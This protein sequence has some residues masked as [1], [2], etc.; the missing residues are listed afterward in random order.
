MSDHK[1]QS[2]N[3]RI[4]LAGA[5]LM[6]ITS[7]LLPDSVKAQ[8]QPKRGGHVRYGVRGGSTTDTLNP[9]TYSN[10]FT[11]TL[12]YAFCNTLTEIDANNTLRPEL[13]QSYE[14]E[15]GAK[16]WIFKLRS[17][18][19]F[20]NGKPLTSTDVM[21]SINLHRGDDSKSPVKSLLAGIQ[22]MKA[23]DAHTI[24]FELT[25]GNADFPY[26]FS[27]FHIMI[28]PEKDGLA[29][30]ASG[31]GT[32]AYVIKSFEPGVRAQV[33]RN[34]NYWRK[35]RAFFDSADIIVMADATARQN[36]LITG[37][38]DVIDQVDLKTVHL[39]KRSPNVDVVNTSGGLYYNYAMNTT[40]APFNNPDVRLALKYGIDREA[41]L[42]KVLRG[43]GK[44]G[45]DQP[46]SSTTKFFAA[47]VEQRKYDPDQAKFHLKKAGLDSL[48]TSLSASDMLYPGAVDGITIYRESLAPAGINLDVVREPSDG[49][50]SSVW[51][52][53]PFTAS[54]WAPRPTA[55]LIFSTTY[56]STAKW[57]D[58]F[59]KNERFDNVLLAARSELDE[60][61]RAEMYRELQLLVRDDGGNVIPLF[62]DH[63]FAMSSQIG[64]SD[65]M[66]GVW[67]LDGGRSLERWWRKG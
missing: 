50:F 60:A 46:I 52:K 25:E 59:W 37:G 66:S 56:L 30:W 29:D 34:P 21:A 49:Y 8:S 13:L 32:G 41:L 33:E 45:N 16:T 65:T 64:H 62:A 47:D 38:L 1:I 11:R 6:G 15:P 31:I 24:R 55:D 39:L 44:I 57:N 19:V 4:L 14:A 26:I 35:D 43:Y 23:E 5:A 9:T 20:H 27:D 7:G 36:A 3:R 17:G 48:S 54:Y 12:G 67:E 58:T 2:P 63:V 28:V 18:I 53:K 10:S 61:K 40:L 51:M 22:S 42:Q